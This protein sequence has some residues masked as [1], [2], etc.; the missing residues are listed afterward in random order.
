VSDVST[1]GWYPDPSRRFELRYFNGQR[2]T[3][4]VST[5]GQRMI[6]PAGTVG[7]AVPAASAAAPAT[8]AAPWSAG[9]A[10]GFAGGLAAGVAGGFGAPPRPKRG[11]AIAAF[12]LAVSAAAVGWFP[13]VFAL[14]AIAA[15]LAFVFGVLG[16]RNARR[17]DGAGR[18]FAT[19]AL[20][21]SPIALAICVGGLFFTRFLVDEI[22]RY[23]D[24]GTYDLQTGECTYDGTTA[25]LS[26]TIRNL[27]SDTRSYELSVSYGHDGVKLGSDLVHVD[28]VGAGTTTA[29]SATQ[30]LTT[31][32]DVACSVTDVH[33]PAPLGVQ[34][35]G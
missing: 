27:E 4:D 13:F 14:A 11:M 2:W 30:A 1:P 23:N 29:W 5:H 6:D 31:T 34:P 3:G 35:A 10:G 28:H 17:N 32:G 21:I 26:G 25:T 16:L 12:V 18:G 15:L 24:P 19:A 7:Q 8:S 9:P 20:W 22:N 33:G